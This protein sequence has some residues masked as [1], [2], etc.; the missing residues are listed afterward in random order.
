MT[1]VASTAKQANGESSDKKRALLLYGGDAEEYVIPISDI[2]ITYPRN[3][4]I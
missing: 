3:F 4:W 2:G 1:V